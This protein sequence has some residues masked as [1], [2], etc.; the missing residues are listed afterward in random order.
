MRPNI[1]CAY[2]GCYDKRTYYV[3][4]L[5]SITDTSNSS[6]K[7]ICDKC[8]ERVG[9]VLDSRLDKRDIDTAIKEIEDDLLDE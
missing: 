9:I 4:S 3:L 8:I 6:T 7:V 1:S 5:T 2:C